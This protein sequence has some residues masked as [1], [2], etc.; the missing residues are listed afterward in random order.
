MLKTRRQRS[1]WA[2][3]KLSMIIS[4]PRRVMIFI[5]S[6]NQL[7]IFAEL[8]YNRTSRTEVRGLC[9]YGK[10]TKKLFSQLFPSLIC[11][12]AAP[13]CCDGE[14]E[15]TSFPNFS[16]Y[17]TYEFYAFF[18]ERWNETNA[19][20]VGRRHKEKGESWVAAKSSVARFYRRG[21]QG[22][23]FLFLP[24]L[25]PAAGDLLMFTEI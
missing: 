4:I 5:N 13:L 6:S 21:T 7:K 12:R 14:N 25:G 10:N 15:Y 23:S 17:L 22:V 19:R 24:S 18:N 1:F 3:I 2:R 16:Q 8:I 20:T 9:F 11:Q